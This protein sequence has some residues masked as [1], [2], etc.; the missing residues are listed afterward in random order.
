MLK[1]KDVHRELLVTDRIINK[2]DICEVDD[3]LTTRKN[4]VHP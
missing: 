1:N 3:A 2:F 4:R